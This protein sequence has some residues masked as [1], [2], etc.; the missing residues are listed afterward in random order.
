MEEWDIYD[1]HRAK[2]DHLMQRGEAFEKGNYHLVVHAC[3]FNQRNEMLIQKRQPFKE[4]WPNMWDVSAGGSALRNETSQ[5]AMEREAREE[6]GLV[7]D[8]KDIRPQLTINFETGFDDFY[9]IE[10]EI[11]LQSLVLQKE[12][13]QCVQWASMEEILQKIEENTFIPYYKSFI[14]LLFE[15]KGHMGCICQ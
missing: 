5:Q 11:D 1:I 9:L 6:I 12:E 2:T 14:Q 4:G 13:V 7:L 15:A 8:L 3:I 10:K